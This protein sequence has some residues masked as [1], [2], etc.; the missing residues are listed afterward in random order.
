MSSYIQ[1]KLNYT[2]MQ[3]AV[4]AHSFMEELESAERLIHGDRSPDWKITFKM[5]EEEVT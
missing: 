2:T 1:R 5:T 3:S 4:Y